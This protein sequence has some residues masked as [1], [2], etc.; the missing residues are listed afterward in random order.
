MAMAS[1]RKELTSTWECHE[2]IK[3]FFN[4][5]PWCNFDN[6]NSELIHNW[7]NPCLSSKLN[8]EKKNN[9]RIK[10]INE[11]QTIY[12]HWIK[13]KCFLVILHFRFFI[14]TVPITLCAP[15]IH[16]S[17]DQIMF[18]FVFCFIALPDNITLC[19][20]L[21]Q[22]TLNLTWLCDQRSAL[23]YDGMALQ[24][25]I[26]ITMSPTKQKTERER[27]TKKLK[28]I[29][30][31]FVLLPISLLIV[32][33]MIV[34]RW[35]WTIDDMVLVLLIVSVVWSQYMCSVLLYV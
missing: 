7:Y 30:R 28:I 22:I 23:N 27:N 16:L 17:S 10:E 31:G 26:G 19:I 33:F 18:G 12:E 34:R 8:E 4:I 9:H 35:F 1:R 6:G 3:K 5:S 13:K 24:H 29:A 15:L 32:A 20:C 11:L 21:H 25:W 2:Y 14:T